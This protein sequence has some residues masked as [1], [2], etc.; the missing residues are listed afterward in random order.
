MIVS[1]VAAAITAAAVTT[2]DIV[3]LTQDVTTYMLCSYSPHM[4]MGF[5]VFFFF[6]R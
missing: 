5:C 1:A 4:Y 6:G 2:A 3:L